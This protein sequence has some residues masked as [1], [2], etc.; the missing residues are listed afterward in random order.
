MALVTVLLYLVVL[1]V[2]PGEVVAGWEG[3][4]FAAITEVVSVIAVGASLVL[5]P[6]AFW[7]QPHDRYLAGFFAATLIS[8]IAWGWFGGA[9]IALLRTGPPMLCYFLL[10]ASIRSARD[11]RWVGYTI[12]A[13]T[14]FQAANGISQFK[15]GVGLGGVS[16]IDTHLDVDADNEDAADA[17]ADGELDEVRRIRGTGIFNDPNDLAMVFVIAVPLLLGP[18]LR[19]GSRAGVRV[20][21]SGA[22]APIVTALYYTNSRGG[23]LGLAAA[24]FPYCWRFG[25]TLGIVLT[26]LGLTALIALGPSRL[27]LTS[28]GETSTQGRLQSWYAGLQMFKSRPL[29]GVGFGRYTEFN[30]LVAHNSF[31]QALAELGIVGAFCFAG[32]IYWLFRGTPRASQ[33]AR[34]DPE[35]SRLSAWGDNLRRGSIGLCVCAMFLSREH[36]AV[37]INWLALSACY[38]QLLQQS[39]PTIKGERL[40]DLAAVGAA[41]VGATVV[42]DVVVRA[43]VQ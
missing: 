25:K 21:A 1:Y 14:L 3:F 37:L 29:L 34:R 19:K 23:V 11:L 4:P 24:V 2:R 10:R 6:R 16:A 7:R 41:T 8:N 26:G 9:Y 33:A 31:I 43:F 30:T 39:D 35:Q 38:Y 27:S 20:L 12:L 28:S 5:R 32:M 36:S 13:A 17:N 22:L 42:V 18:I 40:W 15:T